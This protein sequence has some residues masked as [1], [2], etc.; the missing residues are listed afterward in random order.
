MPSLPA[1][2]TSLGK[3]IRKLRDDAGYS[4]ERFGFAIKRHRTYMGLV[5]RGKANPT[6]KTLHLVAEGLGVSV[7]E[8][9]ALAADEG[10]TTLT[11]TGE[12]RRRQGK[13][14]ETLINKP[15]SAGTRRKSSTQGAKKPG[16]KRRKPGK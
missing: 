9:F 12:D 16:Q 7:P 2:L 4:Q 13:D 5:E 14:R 3:V 15:I 8:L 6:V 1:L 10:S 11:A